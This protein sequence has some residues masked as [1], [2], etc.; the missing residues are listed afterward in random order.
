MMGYREEF[1]DFMV[2]AK[3]LRFGDF[4]TKSGRRSPYFIDTG[5]YTTGRQVS[6]LGDYYA[7]C[8][9][10]HGVG[11]VDALFGPAYKGIPL[12]VAT[13]IS[14][15]RAH[16]RDM[17]YCFNRKE[18][19]DHGEGGSMVG[20][21]PQDGDRIAIL[22]DVVTAGTSV[23]ESIPL[24]RAA[25]NV[26]VTSLFVAVDRQE[27]GQ[28]HT[29]TLEE[30]TAEFGI[31]IHAIVTLADIVAH[32]HN[33]EVDGQVLLT[34]DVKTRLDDYISRYCVMGSR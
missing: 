15:H 14:L 3:A 4:I 1:I 24:L 6:K 22:D 12:V 8:L 27:K 7:A 16:D 28:G 25:A 29:S 23:R 5:C 2:R 33:R 11:A 19:K 18:R 32:L 34:D 21:Q 30:L 9:V 13:A 17:R 20:Y 10:D 31:A 26:T